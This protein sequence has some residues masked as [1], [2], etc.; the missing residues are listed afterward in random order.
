ML[1][2][3]TNI[4][5]KK[6]TMKKSKSAKVE[7]RKISLGVFGKIFAWIA[8]I[9]FILAA[10]DAFLN[11]KFI[12]GTALFVLGLIILPLFDTFLKKYAKIE[13]SG[14]IKTIMALTVLGV[15]GFLN[16]D[17]FEKTDILGANFETAIIVTADNEKDGV[18]WEYQYLR[19]NACN[20]KGYAKVLGQS[21]ET[22]RKHM[23]DRIAVTC[24]DGTNE[25]Y[26]FDIDN[27]FG[28]LK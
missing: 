18:A 23:Y 11:Y 12:Y 10:V 13:L 4:Q 2:L 28:K 27:F 8:S 24:R 1:L 9:T 17:Q 7:P 14:G 15:F 16:L 26:Y 21:L 6:Y 20:K 19:A 5:I 25:A 3:S 22:Y